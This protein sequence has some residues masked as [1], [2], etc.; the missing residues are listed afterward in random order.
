[1]EFR[2]IKDEGCRNLITVGIT[3][4]FG[5]GKTTVG[6]IFKNEGIPYFSFDAMV[7]NL[8]AQDGI[9]EMIKEIF[10][11]KVIKDGRP[12]RKAIAEIVFRDRL[13]KKK[14]EET[15][16]PLVF[17]RYR[18]IVVDYK[19]KGGII[20]FEIPLLFETKSERFFN[21]II[22]VSA[23]LKKIIARLKNTFHPEEVNLR[24][25]N[26]I[27]LSEKEKKAAYIVDN[28]GSFDNTAK[29]VREIIKELQKELS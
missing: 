18:Q 2:D 26:Q 22:V 14:L 5:S 20:V 3:G 25:R 12:D 11:E 10:G 28:S 1:M 16:H 8:F 6:N 9:V 29:Q 4:I 21:K 27:P 15:I 24:I 7:H 17:R 19:K 13:L 23:S